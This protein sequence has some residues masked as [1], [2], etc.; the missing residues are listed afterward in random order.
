MAK[1]TFAYDAFGSVTLAGF[2]ANYKSHPKKSRG[3]MWQIILDTY[4]MD[5]AE[6]AS[7]LF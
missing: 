6:L 7:C 3:N 1:Q 5:R 4:G 2:K